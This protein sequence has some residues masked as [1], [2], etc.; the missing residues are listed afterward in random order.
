MEIDDKDIIEAI[1][2]PS[3]NPNLSTQIRPKAQIQRSAARA[4]YYKPAAT[5]ENISY[6]RRFYKQPQ[7]EQ[8]N[9]S[10]KSI[11]QKIVFQA[12]ICGGFLAVLLFANIIDTPATNSFAAWISRNIQRDLVSEEG[13]IGGFINSITAFFGSNTEE[14]DSTDEIDV[15]NPQPQSLRPNVNPATNTSLTANPNRSRI[16]ESLLQKINEMIEND[17]YLINNGN[18]NGNSN[19]NAR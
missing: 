4:R 17:A 16:D 1:S 10:A 5:T 9:R 8:Q 14:S 11:K 15:Y 12:I 2:S 3:P 18:G 7:A 6:Q 19:I 13:G